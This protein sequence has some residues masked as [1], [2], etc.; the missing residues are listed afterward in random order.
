MKLI[1][2]VVVLCLC[3]VVGASEN[4]IQYILYSQEGCAPCNKMKAALKDLAVVWVEGIH[5]ANDGVTANP[6][7]VI[8]Q[9]G[10]EIK[11]IV[12]Y[13]TKEN[14]EKELAIDHCVPVVKAACVK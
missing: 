12:G 6:T 11:R 3:C 13:T 4:K 1:V 10:V 5:N 8:I 7:L 9:D 14:F 2:A